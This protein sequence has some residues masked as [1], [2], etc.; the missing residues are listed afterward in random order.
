MSEEVE[1]TKLSFDYILRAG[2]FV[3]YLK[4]DRCEHCVGLRP[5]VVLELVTVI[6]K[7]MEH[8]QRLIAE[9]EELERRGMS[10]R[11]GVEAIERREAVLGPTVVQ[12]RADPREQATPEVD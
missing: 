8:A 6:R 10:H 12:W 5:E 1:Y 4:E 7:Q 3:L 2:V 9:L 11:E